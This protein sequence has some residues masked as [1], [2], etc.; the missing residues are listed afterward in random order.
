MKNFSSF[1][2]LLLIG[3]IA[4]IL[5]NSG[6]LRFFNINPNL[7][8]LFI[9]AL[10]AT[11]AKNSIIVSLLFFSLFVGF[12]LYPFWILEYSLLCLVGFL[13]LFFRSRLTGNQI[14]DSLI[15]SFSGSLFFS[16]CLWFFSHSSFS[17]SQLLYQLIYDLICGFIFV[18]LL[19]PIIKRG[20]I[21]KL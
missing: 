15:L 11:R 6:A 17:I 16:L 3:V 18:L 2:F 19:R 10:I 20:G 13:L 4:L 14:S 8:L 12:V 21:S 1:L 9:I 5:M 7:F